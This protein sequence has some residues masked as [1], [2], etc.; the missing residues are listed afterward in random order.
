MSKKKM[1][2]RGCAEDEENKR[3]CFTNCGQPA[4]GGHDLCSTQDPVCLTDT[5]LRAS[6]ISALLCIFKSFKFSYFLVLF[7]KNDL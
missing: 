2:E 1:R 3:V 7:R 6:R 5:H 4:C